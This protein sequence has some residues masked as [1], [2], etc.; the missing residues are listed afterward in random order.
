MDINNI[1]IKQDVNPVVDSR[2]QVSAEEFN[3]IVDTVKKAIVN[4]LGTTARND[5]LYITHKLA[6]G[7]NVLETQIPKATTITPGIMSKD[8][9]D[10]LDK[11]SPNYPLVPQTIN[12]ESYNVATDEDESLTLYAP[13][14][15][16]LEGYILAS[17]GS[18]APGWIPQAGIKAGDAD[19]A[20]KADNATKAS[21]D[22]A[23]NVITQTYATKA[24]VDGTVQEKV[25]VALA[26]TIESTPETIAQLREASD[27]LKS[28]D[29]GAQALMNQVEQNKSAIEERSHFA[30]IPEFM[31]AVVD[32]KGRIIE[33]TAPNGDK[34]IYG[35]LE[36]KKDIKGYV[37]EIIGKSLI[38]SEFSESLSYIENKEWL[39]AWQDTNERIVFGITSKGEVVLP[40]LKLDSQF[41]SRLEEA[42]LRD[43]FSTGGSSSEQVETNKKNITLLAERVYSVEEQVSEV[44]EESLEAAVE[45]ANKVVSS[46]IDGSTF[47]AGL[48]Q[49]INAAGGGTINNAA[50]DEDLVSKTLPNGMSVLKLSDRTYLPPVFSGLGTVILRKNIVNGKNIL[51]PS[52]FDGITNTTFVIRYDFNLDGQT[53]YLEDGNRLY[54]D[55]GSIKNGI[56]IL[57]ESNEFISKGQYQ[58]FYD[59]TFKGTYSKTLP[60]SMLGVVSDGK[61][62]YHILSKLPELLV[63][64]DTSATKARNPIFSRVSIDGTIICGTNGINLPGRV[65]MYGTN[66]ATIYFTSD[67]GEYCMSISNSCGLYNMKLSSVKGYT[68]TILLSSTTIQD[69]SRNLYGA[70]ELTLDNVTITGPVYSTENVEEKP[71]HYT[72]TGFK[73]EASSKNNLNFFYFTHVKLNNVDIE[74]VRVGLDLIV[75]NYPMDGTQYAWGNEVNSDTLY[76]AAVETGIRFRTIENGNNI[77][78]LH[79]GYM[80]INNFEFQSLVHSG[81]GFDIQGA[82]QVTLLRY[83]SWDNDVWGIVRGGALVRILHDGSSSENLSSSIATDSESTSYLSLTESIGNNEYKIYDGKLDRR[84]KV[85]IN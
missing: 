52:V 85:Y 46:P 84:F 78:I 53:L 40:K 13:T 12:G 68:G 47:T 24:E 82:Q 23:G 69:F 39:M 80:C 74:F 72:A 71:L 10:K 1:P 38:D 11:L 8:D 59:V 63:E 37:K 64:Y 70:S 49:Q 56:I 43:G 54:F 16:G 62:K 66:N 76:I 50:D 57:Q 19:H 26:D 17:T 34:V 21:Q 51:S 28:D 75:D 6:G 77:K 4:K 9:K 44:K 2:T 18:G 83:M 29:S 30:E 65:S 79:T 31:G 61:D 3:C 60:L 73:L 25:D 33:S 45:A 15:A 36:V 20:D 5:E 35:G 58:C 22:S 67:F 42:L 14:E 48:W 41:L 7:A 27:W 32:S 55:G 81:V